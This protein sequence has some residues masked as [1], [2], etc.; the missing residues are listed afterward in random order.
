MCCIFSAP[1]RS[2]GRAFYQ[3]PASSAN[4]KVSSLSDSNV[5]KTHCYT[6]VDIWMLTPPGVSDTMQYAIEK[7][8]KMDSLYASW[9]NMTQR[10]QNS[11]GLFGSCTARCEFVRHCTHGIHKHLRSSGRHY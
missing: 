6:S 5:P 2:S 3:Q 9:C 4:F 7:G 10:T 8:D 1:A 11:P